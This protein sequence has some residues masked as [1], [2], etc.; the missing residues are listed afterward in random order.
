MIAAV[1]TTAA[2][3]GVTLEVMLVSLKLI[4]DMTVEGTGARVN[5]MHVKFA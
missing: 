5:D 1:A 2:I 4:S 3:K